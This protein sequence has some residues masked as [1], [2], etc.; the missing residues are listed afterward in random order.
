MWSDASKTVLTALSVVVSRLAFHQYHVGRINAEGMLK[1]P[2]DSLLYDA[3][4]EVITATEGG[5]VIPEVEAAV[6]RSTPNGVSLLFAPAVRG[7]RVW[8]LPLHF[9]NCGTP[10]MAMALLQRP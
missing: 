9:G 1:C 4:E 2:Q 10:S 6:G 5:A 8:H 7:G 3:G